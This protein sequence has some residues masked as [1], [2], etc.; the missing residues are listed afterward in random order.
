MPYKLIANDEEINLDGNWKY[1]LGAQTETLQPQTFFRNYPAGLYNGMITPLSNYCVTGILWYQG[2]SNT[3]N[4][5]GYNVLFNEL[6]ND[7]RKNWNQGDIPFLFTQLANLDTGD[8]NNNW[9]ILREEQ[10]KGLGVPNT[11]MAVTIDIGEYNDLHPQDKKTLG[12]RLALAALNKAY[13]EDIVY[14]GPLYKEM[15]RIEERSEEHTLNSSH[16]AISY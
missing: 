2:E 7:W 3:A 13:G 8:P 15:Q 1:R 10:R 16:V 4:P 14:S 6:V 12:E 11:A 5:D 9:A